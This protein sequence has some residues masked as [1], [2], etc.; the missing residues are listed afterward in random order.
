M[1][2]ATPAMAPKPV[3]SILVQP[4]MIISCTG[5]R[6]QHPTSPPITCRRAVP[7]P[8]LGN[9]EKRLRMRSWFPVS[10]RRSASSRMKYLTLLRLSFPL[11]TRSLILPAHS[12]SMPS[13]CH[14]QTRSV[15]RAGSQHGKCEDTARSAIAW[16]MHKRYKQV[17]G[18]SCLE[19]PTAL[20]WARLL[21]GH[22]RLHQAQDAQH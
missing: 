10:S 19:Q 5:A 9:L 16:C 18:D 1:Q 15:L 12:C 21:A 7:V 17:A 6:R 3:T 22:E 8:A 14:P 2:S 13:A 11:S 4:G 20:R